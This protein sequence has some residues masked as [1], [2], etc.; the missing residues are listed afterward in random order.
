MKPSAPS[1]INRGEEAESRK[2]HDVAEPLPEETVRLAADGDAAARRRLVE[3]TLDGVWAL[4]LRL[5]RRRDEADEIVQET[6]ARAL[7]G[8]SGWDPRGRFEGYLARIATNLVW[9]RWRRERPTAA[10]DT[11]WAAPDALEPWQRVADAEDQRLRLAAIWEAARR[12]VPKQRAAFL[13]Y[14]AQGEPHEAIA[15]ILDA[16][17]GTVK[18]WLHRARLEVRRSA[19]TLLRTRTQTTA[20]QGIVP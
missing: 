5:L 4:A 19:E 18:T 16:P 3:A 1:R 2:G 14:H 6:Y 10:L 20:G 13:L 11:D 8:L 12:L 9:E 15:R 17:V 7:A